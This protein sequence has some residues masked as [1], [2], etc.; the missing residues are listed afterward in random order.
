MLGI[1]VVGLGF[2][3][4]MIYISFLQLKRNE[5]TLFETTAWI[6]L[7]AGMLFVTIFPK[8]LNFL[9]KDVLNL[10]RHLDFY[11]ILGFLFFIFATFFNYMKV[12]SNDKKIEKLVRKIALKN[13]EPA[14]DK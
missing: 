5:F 8:S 4:F 1:Q 12:R 2:G 9:V 14:K 11:L 13:V 6:T 10:G 3:I 7:W